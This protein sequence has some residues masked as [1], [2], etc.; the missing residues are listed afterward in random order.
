MLTPGVNIGFNC[1]P[2][3]ILANV[4]TVSDIK[5]QENAAISQSGWVHYQ[6]GITSGTCG[7]A[8]LRVWVNNNTFGSPTVQALNMNVSGSESA[9]AI[10][11]TGWESSYAIGGYWGQGST[12]A[13]AII[14]DDVEI[15][16]TFDSSFYEVAGG[17]P[18]AT[19]KRFRFKTAWLLALPAL[20][21]G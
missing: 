21:C 8:D 5:P 19:P 4:P 15:S 10:P 16:N 14:F 17:E 6:L 7:N 18:A 3:V 9:C 1:A 20:A 13:T 12:T 2:F 11:V